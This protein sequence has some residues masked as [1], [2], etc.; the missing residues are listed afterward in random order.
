[1]R[2][3]RAFFNAFIVQNPW[4][5]HA[6]DARGVERPIF[7]LRAYWI[8]QYFPGAIPNRVFFD[9]RARVISSGFASGLG[10]P[11]SVLLVVMACLVF[12]A[13]KHW[14]GF[15]A[16]ALVFVLLGL[17]LLAGFVAGTRRYRMP[18]VPEDILAAAILREWLCPVCAFKLTRIPENQDGR[19]VC[20]EC[21]MHWV[22]PRR[23]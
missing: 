3:I 21:G 8:R 14:I 17:T 16:D 19:V 6:R 13:I 23:I 10:P 22:M 7:K 18:G 5:P 2:I 1:M 9:I 20:P 11:V 15:G 12:V 4:S